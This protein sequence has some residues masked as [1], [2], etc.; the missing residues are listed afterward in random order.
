MLVVYSQPASN[1]KCASAKILLPSLP[2]I[3]NDNL[4]GGLPEIGEPN[5]C[6]LAPCN[7]IFYKFTTNPSFWYKDLT[8]KFHNVID[9]SYL[10]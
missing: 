2:I 4:C 8:V 6:G 5:T 7:S 1:D 3:G 9:L 10:N